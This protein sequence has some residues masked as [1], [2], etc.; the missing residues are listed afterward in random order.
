MTALPCG[1][2][3]SVQ[4]IQIRYLF[5]IYLSYSCVWNPLKTAGSPLRN[6]LCSCAASAGAPTFQLCTLWWTWKVLVETPEIAAFYSLFQ[7]QK[8][9]HW[10]HQET[11]WWWR[12]LS[13]SLAFSRKGPCAAT[14]SLGNSSPSSVTH[15]AVACGKKNT[16]FATPKQP[17]KRLQCVLWDIDCFQCP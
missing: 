8:T 5:D 9:I 14:Q 12:D 6:V 15:H 4:S 3:Q 10:L 1:F 2:T 13:M 16:P 7:H 11:R 17:S